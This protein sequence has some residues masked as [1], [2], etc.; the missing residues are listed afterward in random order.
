LLSSAS[1]S[2]HIQLLIHYIYRLNKTRRSKGSHKCRLINIVARGIKW[3]FC[4]CCK[5]R[6]T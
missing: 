3:R 4:E 6:D 1:R 5:T 2:K